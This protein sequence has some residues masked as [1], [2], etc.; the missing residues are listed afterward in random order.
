MPKTRELT[1]FERGEIVG[2]SKGGHSIRNISEILGHP[3]S[4]VQDVITKYKEGSCADAAP[5]SGRPPA[6]SEQDKCQLGRVVKKNRK[7]AVEEITEQFNQSLNISVSS[8]TVTRTLHSMGYYGRTGRKKPLV[9]EVNKKKRLFWC[10]D[11][12]IGK[13]NGILLFLVMNLVLNYLEMM[14]INGFGVEFMRHMQK[15]V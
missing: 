15:I 3:K 1:P 11:K 9:S 7:K 14:L 5:R 4:T 12:K 2:L 13:M 8:K 6:L 10:Y